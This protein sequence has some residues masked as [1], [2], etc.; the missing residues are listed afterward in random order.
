MDRMDAKLFKDPVHGYIPVERALCRA[1]ID[2]P[3]FQRLRHIEQTSMRPLYPGAHH[4]RFIHSLGV[5]HLARMALGRLAKP[6]DSVSEGDWDKLKRSFEIACLMHDCGHA[7]FS[8]TCEHFYNH[9][10]TE[11]ARK[12]AEQWLNTLVDAGFKSDIPGTTHAAAHE[13]FSAALLIDTYRTEVEGLGADVY[14]AA[15]M[16]T[17]YR[18][19]PPTNNF[20]KLA[21]CFIELL[22]GTAIDLDK[23]DYILRDTWAS[24]VKNTAVDVERLLSSIEIKPTPLSF[25]LCF[26]KSAMSVIQ[27]VV[28]ARNYLFEWIYNHHTVVYY[29][30]LLDAALRRLARD[31]DPGGNPDHFWDT[32]FSVQP[33]KAP[34]Q[35]APGVNIYLPSDGD[36]YHLLKARATQPGYEMVAELLSHNPSRFPLWKTYGEFKRLFDVNKI[37]EKRN[38]ESVRDKIPDNLARFSG[39][40]H[41]DSEFLVIEAKSRVAC[42]EPNDIML[43]MNENDLVSYTALFG[44]GIP[45]A[46]RFF[47]VFAPNA[48]RGRAQELRTEVCRLFV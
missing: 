5:Y 34:A 26:H 22:N 28:D 29:A 38:T 42:I 14:L 36:L 47:Y 30:E 21:N 10:D 35:L 15:R 45:Y 6:A 44:E 4:D 16:I 33:F 17:G 43:D 9:S 40:T 1:F 18:F 11:E 24:G 2:K 20:E 39:N 27:S 13:T 8:H 19:A 23:L 12:R 7:P 3:I 37:D 48:L 41:R 46:R 25:R 31:L 32:V